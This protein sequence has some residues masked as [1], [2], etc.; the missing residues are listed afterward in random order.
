MQEVSK[1]V[2]DIQPLLTI[3]IPT[4]NRVECLKLLINSIV[5][6]TSENFLGRNFELLI[7]NNA[8]TDGTEEYLNDLESLTGIRVVNH[9]Q[10][11]GAVDNVLHCFDLAKGQFV[12]VMGDDD[13]PLMGAINA[14]MECIECEQP[15]LMYL[16][17][18]WVVGD[19][20]E[21]AKNRILTNKVSVTDSLTLAVRASVYV[22]F[23]SSWIVNKGLYLNQKN[24]KIDRYRDTFLPQLEWFFTLLANEKKFVYA[25][26]SWVVARSGSSGGYSVFETFS[27]Q[28]N[29]IV[30][31][32]FAEKPYLHLFFKRCMLWCFIPSAIWGMRKRSIGDFGEFNKVQ[33]M[34]ILRSAYGNDYFLKFV[35]TPMVV[36]NVS[37]AWFFWI[38]ARILSKTWLYVWQKFSTYHFTNKSS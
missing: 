29:C 15:A 10:N 4:F 11:C 17:S 7:C 37:V 21:L 38:F 26:D 32:K 3:A 14:V 16:P 28:Y 36:F 18:K 33:T 5:K 23:L 22:T 6:Q 13:V 12:W 9:T 30:D 24:A 2:K 27:H 34:D 25:E 31:R 20:G 8:S 1:S 19:L 35:V